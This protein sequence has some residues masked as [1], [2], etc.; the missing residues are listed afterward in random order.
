MPN[1]K[2]LDLNLSLKTNNEDLYIKL[3]GQQYSLKESNIFPLTIKSM[4]E[5]IQIEFSGFNSGASVKVEMLY[6]NKI[7]DIKKISSYKTKD[8]NK[9]GYDI[10]EFD[11]ILTF[12]F[13]NAWFSTQIL[14]GYP[15]EK[16]ETWPYHLVNDYD[17]NKKHRTRLESY[18]NKSYDVAFVGTCHNMDLTYEQG[19]KRDQPTLRNL[20]AEKYTGYTFADLIF[21]GVGDWAMMHNALWVCNNIKTRNLIVTL[22]TSLHTII[23]SRFLDG[24]SY[25]SVLTKNLKNDILEQ[26]KQQKIHEYAE[27][28]KNL[29]RNL[30]KNKLDNLQKKC[31]NLGINLIV[32]RYSARDFFFANFKHLDQH[33]ELGKNKNILDLY[34][35]NKITNESNMS[36]I[37]LH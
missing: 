10:I 11:G 8:F 16:D 31:D 30:L 34:E 9:E 2:S 5:N 12:Q 4:N 37:Q 22:N 17:I 36:Q 21:Y 3:N 24:I 32:I 25:H 7:L 20:L 28:R 14:N 23:K 1:V 33:K 15:F 35:R 13:F 27:K 18:K 19:H 29:W 26:S 6:N